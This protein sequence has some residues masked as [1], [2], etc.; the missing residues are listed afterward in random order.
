MGR[1]RAGTASR[2]TR[3]SRARLYSLNLVRATKPRRVDG[4]K[5]PEKGELG[6]VPVEPSLRPG[7][8]SHG[9]EG[10]LAYSVLPPAA[11]SLAEPKT[12]ALQPLCQRFRRG[13]QFTWYA[14]EGPSKRIRTRLRLASARIL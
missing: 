12:L 11:G 7:C 5:K 1:I 4:K 6:P 9:S 3:R 8:L 14:G 10:A 13:E 2:A